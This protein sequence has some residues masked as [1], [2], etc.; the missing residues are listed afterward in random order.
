MKIDP[1]APVV[2]KS[3]DLSTDDNLTPIPD[4]ID[5]IKEFK[6]EGKI[7]HNTIIEDNC[8][9]NGNSGL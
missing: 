7:H 4:N 5:S 3:F 2:V 6:I 8:V 9:R 1:F